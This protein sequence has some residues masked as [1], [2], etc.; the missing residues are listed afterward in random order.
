LPSVAFKQS[1]VREKMATS[2]ESVECQN[3]KGCEANKYLF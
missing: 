3:Q 2:V 1:L